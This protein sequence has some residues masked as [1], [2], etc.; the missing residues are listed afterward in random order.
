[1]KAARGS[2]IEGLAKNT[3]DFTLPGSSSITCKRKTSLN[4]LKGLLLNQKSTS[5]PW[6]M[7]RELAIGN[8]LNPQIGEFLQDRLQVNTHLWSSHKSILQPIRAAA[9]VKWLSSSHHMVPTRTFLDISRELNSQ[10][11]LVFSLKAFLSCCLL[12]VLLILSWPLGGP[13]LSQS[14]LQ[15]HPESSHLGIRQTPS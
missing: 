4:W 6:F 5:N 11:K 1:M 13:F 12:P 3:W 14:S 9:P 8:W 10:V 7:T 2:R 15:N